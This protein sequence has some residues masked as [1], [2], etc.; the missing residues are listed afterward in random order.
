MSEANLQSLIHWKKLQ[1]MQLALQQEPD[2]GGLPCE[3]FAQLIH[4]LQSL[5]LVQ[6]HH[7]R[8]PHIGVTGTS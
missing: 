8:E 7:Y 4:L 3:V 1:V 6:G 2:P 5:A